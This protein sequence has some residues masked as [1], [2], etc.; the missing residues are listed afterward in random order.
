[1]IDELSI[2]IPTYNEEHYLGKTLQSI[3]KQQLPSKFETII[4]DGHSDDKTLQVADSF[5]T[6][7]PHLTV[8]TAKRST[9]H[10]RN[11]GARRAKYKYLIFLDADM[12]LSD[13][14]IIN[15][16]QKSSNKEEFIS[17]VIIWTASKRLVDNFLLTLAYPFIILVYFLHPTVGAGF[18][19]TTKQ[20]HSKIDG[21]NEKAILGEDTDYGNRSILAGAKPH[22]FFSLHVFHSPRRTREKGVIGL[23]IFWLRAYVYM[24]KNGLVYDTKKFSYPYGHYKGDAE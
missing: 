12:I 17:M 6:K 24:Q 22:L 8:L 2:V 3:Q 9:G 16:L 15:L 5:Q 13:N 7:I 10:Q 18:I 11:V 14:F 1:M 20:N 19:F 21:F 4:V 23:L